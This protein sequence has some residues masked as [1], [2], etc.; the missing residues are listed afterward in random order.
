MSAKGITDKVG[1]L[2]LIGVVGVGAAFLGL[3][4]RDQ[5]V[6][7]PDGGDPIIQC[8]IGFHEENGICVVDNPGIPTEPT[9][10]FSQSTESVISPGIVGFTVEPHDPRSTIL[11]RFGDGSNDVLNQKIVNHE[12]FSNGNFQGSVLITDS[13]GQTEEFPFNV[14]V[15]A[16]TT[17]PGQVD[18]ITN[19]IQSDA[20][21]FSGD[22]VGFS[23]A[24]GVAVDQ[25]IWE[26]GDGSN[27]VLN[28]ISVDHRYN[29]PGTFT[30]FVEAIASGGGSERIPFTVTVQEAPSQ[31]INLS[32]EVGALAGS[33]IEPGETVDLQAQV[34]GGIPPFVIFDW[35]FGD[36]TGDLGTNRFVNHIYNQEGNFTVKLTVTDSAGNT[37]SASKLLSV[38]SLPAQFGDVTISIAETPQ[39]PFDFDID[40]FNNRSDLTIVGSSIVRVFDGPTLI[41]ARQNQFSISPLRSFTE[42]LDIRDNWR[43]GVPLRMIVEYNDV[44]GK[45]IDDA[46]FDF[47]V[48]QDVEPDPI[49]CPPGFHQEGGICV[50]DSITCPPG[51]TEVNGV[52]IPDT[53]PAQTREDEKDFNVTDFPVSI[54]QFNP[55]TQQVLLFSLPGN[56]LSVDFARVFVSARIGYETFASMKIIF[57]GEVLDTI[58]YGFG[59]SNQTKDRDIVVTDKIRQ[60]QL[61]ELVLVFE[62]SNVFFPAEAFVNLASVFVKSTVPA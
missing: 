17:P 1:A 53:P 31:V 38:K 43:R 54:P 9:S 56:T 50:A 49:F 14:L 57:N 2:V 28:Q 32:I 52:C 16:P 36:G 27:R 20:V 35:D 62:S 19:F 58:Q 41:H 59:E 25:V 26:F 48:P 10:S 61:N 29:S 46:F 11:W 7:P 8:G 24:F 40:Y 3:R 6:L 45:L 5:V 42:G 22:S 55:K 34:G 21:I 4:R 47:V 18:I 12:Y 37:K 51:F 30:G 60:N 23:L 15:V 33:Q 13:E 44:N 39:G